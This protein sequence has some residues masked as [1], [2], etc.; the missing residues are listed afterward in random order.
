MLVNEELSQLSDARRSFATALAPVLGAAARPADRFEHPVPTAAVVE[1]GKHRFVGQFHWGDALEKQPH[2]FAVKDFGPEKALVIRCWDKTVLGVTDTVEET[3]RMPHSAE[4]YDL[5]PVP[6][7]PCFLYADGHVFGGVNVYDA[8]VENGAWV[9]ER[10]GGIELPGALYGW[11][12]AGQPVVG[13]PVCEVPG[14]TVVKIRSA[15]EATGSAAAPLNPT[16]FVM[17]G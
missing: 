15:L 11:I 10:K 4:L 14:G 16:G 13:E 2:R 9:I 12:P 8:H 7:A 5:I 1:Y 3:L 17:G 6:E